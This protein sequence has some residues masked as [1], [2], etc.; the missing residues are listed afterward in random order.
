MPI[1]NWLNKD[2]AV[3]AAQ[4][5]PY[6]LL[7]G[8]PELSH[9][10]P[11]AD[12]ML[13]Q[14]DNLE[15]LKALLPLYAGKVKCIYI[16][17]PFN[18]QQ[19]FDDYDDNLEHSTWLSLIYPRLELLHELLSEDGT[20]F[21]HIDD[22]ELAYLITIADEIVGRKNQVAIATFKQ[23][24]ATGHK[25]I[26]PGMVNTTNFVLVYAKNKSEWKPHRLF[27]GRE[28]DK[29]YNQFLENPEEHYSQW[30]LVPLSSAFCKAEGKKMN[31]LKRELGPQLLEEKL[32]EFVITHAKQVIQSV[33]PDYSSVSEAAQKIIDESLANP[34]KVFFL[35]RDGYSDMYF[36][37][38]QRWIFYTGK[39]KEIDG[40]LVAGE[41]LTT[42]WDDLLS[43]NLHKEGDVK[44]PKSKKP[45]ALIKRVLDMCTDSGD[46]VLDSFLGSGTTA[47]VAHKMGR[48]YIGIEMGEHAVT[49]CSPRL[50]KVVEGEQGGISKAVSWQ[51]GGGFRFYRLGEPV[52]DEYGAI[53]PEIRFPTLAA[54]I[55]YLETRQPMTGEGDS[56]LLGVHNGTAYYL[57]YNGI[58]GDR[59]PQG[60]NVLTG[61]V[62]ESLPAHDGPKVIY[63]ET[64]R[65][66]KA[67][68]DAEQ[69]TFKQIPYDVRMR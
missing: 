36:K 4:N 56:P 47:A 60:G 58:L 29:R 2:E 45:E 37:G 64:T 24:A 34:A 68:L 26:N 31:E 28:R 12:N 33:R 9:G 14:G 11:E 40:S 42:L 52:F 65:F 38:G 15:A 21:I 63:G 20:I 10:D 8:V 27:T 13:I 59:R 49:H 48:R 18:T 67:R 66:G 44:F 69:I 54:Y 30:K 62:L 39:L 43:N 50:K 35:E 46:I 5:V 16:D 3:R 1:L 32:N 25:A 19:A 17:P 22:N 53:Q 41:P 23:G 55:W 51:G 57:L 7:E 6:R 61:P